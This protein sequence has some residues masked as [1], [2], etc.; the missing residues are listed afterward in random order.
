MDFGK[1]IE[2]LKLPP[3]ILFGVSIATGF[4]SFAE[5]DILMKLSLQNFK[6]K[7]GMWI[8]LIFVVSCALL[9]G[10][11]SIHVW[12]IVQRKYKSIMM[13]LYRKKKLHELTKEEKRILQKYFIE[14]TKSV[15][16]SYNSGIA[17]ELEYFKIIYRS[18]NVSQI[19]LI[20]PYNIQPWAYKYLKKRPKLLQ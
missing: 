15:S 11:M 12:K 14:D 3:T 17:S 6:S 1:F 2:G 9:I 20:F 4:L 18:S 5:N 19:G 7:Y 16:I 8:G 10:Y 13:M